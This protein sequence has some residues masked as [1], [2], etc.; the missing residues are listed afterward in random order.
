MKIKPSTS[1]GN[2]RM[3][4]T[5]NSH[6]ERYHINSPKLLNKVVSSH[7]LQ[8]YINQ[9]H[10]KPTNSLTNNPV[11]IYNLEKYESN[12][13]N[14]GLDNQFLSKNSF[15]T[16]DENKDILLDYSRQ[17]HQKSDNLYNRILDN[18]N[19]CKNS[20]FK[21]K[22][23]VLGGFDYYQ[24]DPIDE[25]SKQTF[26]ETN[27]TQKYR[28]ASLS[29]SN[30]RD[31]IKQNTLANPEYLVQ[32]SNSVHR[33]SSKSGVKVCF[34][35]AVSIFKVENILNNDKNRKESINAQLINKN[36]FLKKSKSLNYLS[37]ESKT[38]KCPR[39]PKL[40]AKLREVINYIEGEY[41]EVN[42]SEIKTTPQ[43]HYHNLTYRKK[44]LKKIK[45]DIKMIGIEQVDPVK[46]AQKYASEL[47][48][49]SRM[50]ETCFQKTW[51]CKTNK[52]DGS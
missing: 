39:D 52:F 40:I 45:E 31:S 43:N 6:L 22:I 16:H 36:E 17:L 4:N 32:R 9:R 38:S 10:G 26:E 33:N 14:I 15:L 37:V 48:N 5:D 21:S 13:Q 18:P 7:R 19:T 49:T 41:P 46:Y 23:K 35:D 44:N 2:N 24:K 34:S 29:R 12:I 47:I 51:K 25:K 28:S 11:D 30:Q 3:K 1:P 27:I 20:N 42:Y 8:T 50:P